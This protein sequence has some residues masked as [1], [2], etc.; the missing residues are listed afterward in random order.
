MSFN[1]V[2]KLEQGCFDMLKADLFSNERFTEKSIKNYLISHFL[3]RK[4]AFFRD[5][6]LLN[7][8]STD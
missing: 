5:L 6:N 8:I 4:L 1:E 7:V 3:L 2:Y